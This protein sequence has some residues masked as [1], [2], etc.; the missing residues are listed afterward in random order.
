MTGEPA[1][2]PLAARLQPPRKAPPRARLITQQLATIGNLGGV[3]VMVAS[4]VSNSTPA[5]AAARQLEAPRLLLEE[6]AGSTIAAEVEG[7][8]HRPPATS[9]AASTGSTGSEALV[10]LQG[11]K[12][13]VQAAAS[14]ASMVPVLALLLLASSAS[15]MALVQLWQHCLPPRGQLLRQ[16]AVAAVPGS[17]DVEAA[18][19]PADPPTDGQP[20]LL[21][22]HRVVA[23]AGTGFSECSQQQHS[24]EEAAASHDAEPP[25]SPG[26][27]G[28]PDSP[29]GSSPSERPLDVDPSVAARDS[30]QKGWAPLLPS[31]PTPT[32]QGGSTFA[33][34]L[35]FAG[36]RGGG[37][38]EQQLT[39]VSEQDAPMGGS[40]VAGSHGDVQWQWKVAV[41]AEAGGDGSGDDEGEQSFRLP[42]AASPAAMLPVPALSGFASPTSTA[43]HAQPA[44]SGSPRKHQRQQ[45]QAGGAS[46]GAARK[47]TGARSVRPRDLPQVD[48]VQEEEEQQ[49]SGSAGSGAPAHLPSSAE[50]DGSLQPEPSAGTLWAVHAGAG[51]PAPP[52]ESQGSSSGGSGR[53]RTGAQQGLVLLTPHQFQEE[54]KMS[55]LLGV[56]SGGSVYAAEWRGQRVAVKLMH[57]SVVDENCR[58]FTRCVLAAGHSCC[59]VLCYCGAGADRGVVPADMMS[60]CPTCLPLTCQGGGGDGDCGA[61]P[62]HR[63]SAGRV[64]GAAPG[65]GAGKSAGG[66]AGSPLA[67]IC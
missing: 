27:P 58:T 3:V 46:I 23:S 67:P 56:G 34:P 47:L 17:A 25:H 62:R 5:A 43:K 55:R 12:Q 45:Q 42:A 38:G 29:S 9:T 20:L 50:G 39:G 26:S 36:G 28:S 10:L 14:T 40:G 53:P 64:P 52:G 21:S 4:T 13:K 37:A 48:H 1:L 18:V 22:S 44:A 51:G 30:S 15:L 35:F 32:R 59:V 63:L 61:A 24:E 65:G 16:S 7:Q 2:L 57:P 49:G 8:P 41:E 54:V 60:L 19:V 11:I 33:N 66:R 6:S 31:P